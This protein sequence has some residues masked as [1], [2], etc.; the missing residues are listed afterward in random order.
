M[1]SITRDKLSH[2]V[3]ASAAAICS[4]SRGRKYRKVFVPD[5]VNA[6]DYDRLTTTMLICNSCGI[7]LSRPCVAFPQRYPNFYK[8]P[9]GLWG[10]NATFDPPNFVHRLDCTLTLRVE[11]F[12]SVAFSTPSQT[13]TKF[14]PL[15][16]LGTMPHLQPPQRLRGIYHPI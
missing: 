11:V 3:R 6:R 13:A 16:T 5:L 14:V 4:F 2:L 8:T 1:A 9:F 12:E 10:W 15:R 7:E